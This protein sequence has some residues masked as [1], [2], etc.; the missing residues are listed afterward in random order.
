M[1][2]YKRAI[3]LV[4]AGALLVGC[5]SPAFAASLSPSC[6]EAFYATLDY[7]GQLQQSSVVKSYRTNGAAAIVDYGVYDQV[8]NLVDG[9]APQMEDGLLTFSFD[10]EIPE[11]F[12]FEG[13]TAQP[14]EQLPW[15]VEI[16]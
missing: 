11:N 14:F 4:A 5:V 6:D 3:S 12:Y 2:A 10:E 16:S 13:K 15:Q 9:K 1:N 8:E 7:Y